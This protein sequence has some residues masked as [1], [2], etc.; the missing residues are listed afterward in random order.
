MFA[1]SEKKGGGW[2]K[3]L[4]H[5]FKVPVWRASWSLTGNILAVTDGN[6][7]VTLWKEALDGVWQQISH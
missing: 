3:K 1:W 6:N 5:D 2:D 7:A 4:V